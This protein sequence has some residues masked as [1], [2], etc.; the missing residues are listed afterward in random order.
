MPSA[1][2]RGEAE[3]AAVTLVPEGEL[4][5][6]LAGRVERDGMGLWVFTSDNDADTPAG[7]GG[8]SGEITLV[9]C[10]MLQALERDLLES[11]ARARLRISGRVL[12]FEGANY[13]LPTL[14]RLAPD[15]GGNL[16][17]AQ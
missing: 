5:I 10:L 17:S 3:N 11:P 13:L 6:D 12:V 2:L 8:L 14:Y 7:E 9:P 1:T 15:V 4:V 16:T